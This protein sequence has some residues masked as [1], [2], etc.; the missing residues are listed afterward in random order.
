MLRA[1]LE[2]RQSVEGP[3]GVTLVHA[4]SSL[5]AATSAGGGGYTYSRPVAVRHVAT[6]V[7]VPIRDHVMVLRLGALTV[8]L[9][10]T[11]VR[12]IR[13]R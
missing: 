9:L 11:I 6:G 10:L 4:H 7:G 12:W 8:I 13:G 2:N 5:H 3:H 1:N